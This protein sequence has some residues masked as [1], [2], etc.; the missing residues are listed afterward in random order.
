MLYYFQQFQTNTKKNNRL[1]A[2][3]KKKITKL[4]AALKSMDKVTMRKATQTEADIERVRYSYQCI[5]LVL[6]ITAKGN[7]YS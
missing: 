4:E 5:K 6:F 3:M 7:Y 1:N 2:E